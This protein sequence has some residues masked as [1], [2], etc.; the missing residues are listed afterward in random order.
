LSNKKKH[1]LPS[2]ILAGVLFSLFGSGLAFAEDYPRLSLRI[3]AAGLLPL[4]I[5][6]FEELNRTYFQEA[7]DWISPEASA[8][9]AEPEFSHFMPG[10]NAELN[11]AVTRV[12]LWDW[13]SA[14]YPASGNRSGVIPM[15]QKIPLKDHTNG[16]YPNPFQPGFIPYFSSQSIHLFAAVPCP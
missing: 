8:D 12:S 9:A 11:L 15:I 4:N 14:G 7:S 10:L 6:W 2:I 13:V 16:I 3:S 1:I 5:Q